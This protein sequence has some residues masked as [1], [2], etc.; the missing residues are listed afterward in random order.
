MHELPYVAGTP[1]PG[2]KE[3]T[4]QSLVLGGG[5]DQFLSYDWKKCDERTHSST[6][7]SRTSNLSNNEHDGT[8]SKQ[9]NWH[10]CK[11]IELRPSAEPASCAATQEFPSILQNP[12]VSYRAYKEPSTGLYPEP[13]E[14]SPYY[15][16]LSIRDL[17]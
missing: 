12:K 8:M 16:V 11:S 5:R 14:S 15:P 9:K 7:S 3:S 1:G 17:S 6:K 4:N 2:I 13:D 10:A